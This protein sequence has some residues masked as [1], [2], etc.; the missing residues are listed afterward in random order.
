MQTDKVWS[1][2][3]R[4]ICC[5][6]PQKPGA[7]KRLRRPAASR[8]DRAAPR[9]VWARSTQIRVFRGGLQ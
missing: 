2:W 6:L 7:A 5:E 1:N 4:C 8:P 9:R 3:S